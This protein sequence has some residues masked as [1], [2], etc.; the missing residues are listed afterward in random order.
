MA[1]RVAVDAMGGDRA[2]EEIVAGARAA[3]TDGI[4]PVLFGPREAIQP[5][6]PDLEIVD[7]PQVVGMHE[8]P[9][10]AAR[11]KRDSSLFAACRAV[12]DGRADVVVSAGNT[13]A[14]LAA[15]LLEIGRL[16]DVSRP[17]IAAPL[18]ARR[19]PSVLIDAGANADAR[20]EHLAQFATMGTIFAEEIIGIPDPSVGLLSI[21]E[22]PEKGN[23]LTRE[24]HALLAAN[25]VRFVGNV[26]GRLLLEGAADVVVCDGFTGNMAL[27]VLEGTIRT[28]LD[29]F[30]EEMMRS[31]RGKVGG[32][33]IRP[34]A[35]GLHGRLD[36]DTYGGGY[37]LGLKGLAVVA[38]GNSSRRAI[39]SAI[40]LGARGVSHRVVERMAERLS[41][42]VAAVRG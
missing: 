2:P 12:G 7:A 13:G 29:S 5:L 36:P 26:E 38:H 22:E 20:P 41:G 27:K 21:G 34:A 19:G 40:Q 9:A 37:L 30:R 14:M 6:A 8:K 28:V 25:G 4:V 11:E 31:R 16:P 35:R 18:P 24:A 1:I 23:R 32:L 42:R 15:G 39:V 10:D 3:R 17:A 33:M